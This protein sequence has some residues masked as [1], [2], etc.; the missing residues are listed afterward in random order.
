MHQAEGA[1]EREVWKRKKDSAGPN[2]TV[3][4]ELCEKKLEDGRL[5]ARVLIDEEEGAS[6]QR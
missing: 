2:A 6:G 3:P 5:C 4:V 1:E